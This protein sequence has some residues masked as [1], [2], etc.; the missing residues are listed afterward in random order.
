M[1]RGGVSAAVREGACRG[2]DPSRGVR[3]WLPSTGRFPR[4]GLTCPGGGYLSVPYISA[5]AKTLLEPLIR[6]RS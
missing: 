5:V 3:R 2:T 1:A 4:K 6:L